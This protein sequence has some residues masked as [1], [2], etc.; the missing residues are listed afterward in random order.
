[1]TFLVRCN[2]CNFLEEAFVSPGTTNNV[3]PPSTTTGFFPS[4]SWKREGKGHTLKHTC[5]E[6]NKREEERED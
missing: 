6:C 1:M 2:T 3:Y 5:P 4:F